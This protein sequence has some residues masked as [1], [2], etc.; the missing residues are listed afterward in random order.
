MG[1]LNSTGAIKPLQ[2]KRSQPDDVIKRMP[3]KTQTMENNV[4][5]CDG[6]MVHGLKFLGL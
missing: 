2:K 1:T 6:H 5:E 4:G 3:V